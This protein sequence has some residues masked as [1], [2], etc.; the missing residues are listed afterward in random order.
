MKK[1]TTKKVL[2]SKTEELIERIKLYRVYYPMTQKELAEK[3]G[4]SERSISR[5][6]NGEDI[7]LSN[8]GKLLRALDLDGNLLLLVPDQRERPSYY[9]EQPHQRSRSRKKKE[10]RTFKW[11]DE[12]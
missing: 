8:F 1:D 7:S 6:E 3:S 5:F 2:D 9:L 12:L 4:V 11:G 10:T